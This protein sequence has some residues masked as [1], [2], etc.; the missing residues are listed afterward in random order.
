MWLMDM[1]L[2]FACWSALLLVG[3][4]LAYVSV[5]LGWKC[6][7]QFAVLRDN[8]IAGKTM[9]LASCLVI[10][11]IVDIV[12]VAKLAPGIYSIFR[13]HGA[14]ISITGD[15]ISVSGAS[16]HWKVMR[17]SVRYI[18]EMNYIFKIEY[19][20]DGITRTLCVHKTHLRR[21]DV[22]Q[23]RDDLASLGRA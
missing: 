19:I 17:D 6:V 1:V 9:L 18:Q 3:I 4:A 11:C 21:R 13:W 23:L 16:V 14:V 2:F 15:A 10:L 7:T 22:L 12:C 20:S 5:D 8:D